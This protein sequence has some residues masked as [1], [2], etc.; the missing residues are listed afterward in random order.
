MAA[1]SPKVQEHGDVHGQ[2]ACAHQGNPVPWVYSL[3]LI[4]YT[5]TALYTA[6]HICTLITG[7]RVGRF[8]ITFSCTRLFLIRVCEDMYTSWP[9]RSR[10]HI[11]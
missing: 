8:L 6:I 10:V 11:C 1:V 9:D 4:I 7:L 5:C 3:H 2:V